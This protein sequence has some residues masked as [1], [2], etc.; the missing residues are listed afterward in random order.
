MSILGR[1]DDLQACGME[2]RLLVVG[3]WLLHAGVHVILWR[4]GVPVTSAGTVLPLALP[5]AAIVLPLMRWRGIVCLIIHAVMV[6]ELLV[7]SA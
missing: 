7:A 6:V 5:S 1:L 2:L 4:A 3:P